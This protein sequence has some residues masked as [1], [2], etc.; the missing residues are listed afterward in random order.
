M[1]FR[2]FLAG[3]DYVLF[4][5][6]I[7]TQTYSKGI[8]RGHCYDEL[9]ISMPE[10]V[11]EI[12]REYLEAGAQVITTNTFGANRAILE[13]YYDLGAKAHEIN[14]YGARLAKQS[15]KGKGFVAGS[16]GPIT[17][18]LDRETSITRSQTE[19]YFRQQTEALLE[20]GADLIIFE[21]FA[22]LGEL[23]IGI[24]AA[25]E[26]DQDLFV[27]ASMSFPSD[28]GLTL[29][30]MNPYQAASRLDDSAADALGSNC[31][32]GPQ[33][34]FETVKKLGQVSGKELAAQPN[35]GLAQFVQ[36][37]FTYPSNP[38]YFARYGEKF[39]AAGVKIIGGCCGTT[40]DHIR[41]LAEGLQGKKPGK[42]R[43]RRIA[44]KRHK[45][46][47]LTETITSPLKTMLDQGSVLALE[48]DPPKDPDFERLAKKLEPLAS[49]LNVINVSDSPMARPRMSP[50]ATGR[51][52]RDHLGLE[53]I[54]HY[55]CRDRNI[56]G[57]QSDLLGA[58]ALGLHNFLALGGDPPSIGDYPFATGV[59]DLTSE[60]LISLISSLNQ[61]VDLLGNPLG[62][63]SGFL[64]G[65]GLGIGAD[66][67]RELD[68]ARTK[69][70]K[71][72]HF[73]ITQPVFQISESSRTLEDLKEA[74]IP[75]ILSVMPLVS[76]R[77]AEYIHYEV[78]GISIPRQYLGRM[79]GT[80]GSSGE[81][82][83]VRIAREILQ[84]LRPLC[85]G[86]LF[87]PPL[88]KY[89]LVTELLES[90]PTN[91]P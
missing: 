25:K 39:L 3:S 2:E 50:I 45:T 56:L 38:E 80:E 68:A 60:S 79:E 12:H 74:G 28:G 10:V 35:A 86:L 48:V 23:L 11:L 78:P 42:R 1:T 53:I 24:K 13:E 34:V 65:A 18:P 21:T 19:T 49:S 70:R 91:H 46:E 40:P 26:L 31:G 82:E 51:L 81:R 41:A 89:H 69:I 55:T 5:G 37:K 77:N 75:V 20:G 9:N 71:G 47:R 52:L 15:I 33:S 17:R 22:D 16:I 36:G 87:M 30:G 83:G 27:I 6:G 90:S 8:P 59:Y 66:R 61:G 57:I 67:K 14:Y 76:G 54:V 63:Q 64:I 62:K 88:G 58:S 4:D 72:A 84:A 29:Y 43:T 32:T 85:S 73:V 7:G 44:V